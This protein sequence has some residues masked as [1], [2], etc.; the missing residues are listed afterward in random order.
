MEKFEAALMDALVN[1]LK[2]GIDTDRYFNAVLD[3][4]FDGEGYGDNYYEI[5]GIHTE[6]G[7]P[8]V[9]SV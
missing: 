2:S 6:N 1:N 8:V 3:E 7:R 9:V 4:K 5:R